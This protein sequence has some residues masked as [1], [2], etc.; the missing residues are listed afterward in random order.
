VYPRDLKKIKVPLPPLEK[1]NKIVA[2]I[3]TIRQEAKQLK[4]EAKEGLEQ[5]KQEVEAIILGESI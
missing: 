5:A 1:Q 3:N 4:Y 2:H